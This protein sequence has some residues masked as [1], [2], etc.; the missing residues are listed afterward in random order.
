M[1]RTTITFIPKIKVYDRQTVSIGLR[2]TIFKARVGSK[3]YENDMECL[4]LRKI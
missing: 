3:V 2:D 1:A 4:F